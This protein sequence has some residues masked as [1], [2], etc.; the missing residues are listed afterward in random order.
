VILDEA[1]AI[2]NPQS[3]ITQVCLSL[4]A[5]RF[6]TLT[7]TPLENSLTDLWSL[8]HFFNRNMLG[9]QS[10]FTRACKQP[11]NRNCIVNY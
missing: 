10:N 4:T 3:D 5:R 9:S 6:L 8:V 7:G 1:Q 2:K 11:E